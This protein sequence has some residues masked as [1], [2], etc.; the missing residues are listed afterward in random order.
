[1]ADWFKGVYTN[2]KTGERQ[3]IRTTPQFYE[4][5]AMS[6]IFE[7]GLRKSKHSE[8]TPN[9]L[10]SLHSPA[11]DDSISK[12]I[13]NSGLTFKVLKVRFYPYQEDLR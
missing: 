7:R 2:P 11:D 12:M 5:S 6:D 3:E 9:D 13:A 4:D 8:R 1:M 10:V